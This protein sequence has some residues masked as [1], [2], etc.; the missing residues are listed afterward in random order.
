M[1]TVMRTAVAL[2][3][4]AV[5]SG[6]PTGCSGGGTHQEDPMSTRSIE[7]VLATH[8]DSLMSLPG[9]VGTAI[10]V[11][12]GTP[13]IRVLVS[14]SSVASRRQIPARLEGYLVRV[15]GTGPLRALDARAPAKGVP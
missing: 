14:D 6:M 7:Q 1:M 13:C 5:T 8:T 2:T 15:D 4:A 9:V 11:C 3:V 12:D 10:G